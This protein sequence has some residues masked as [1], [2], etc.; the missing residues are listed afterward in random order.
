MIRT[1]ESSA[2]WKQVALSWIVVYSSKDKEKTAATIEDY[3]SE[4]RKDRDLIPDALSAAL[5]YLEEE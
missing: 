3:V 4:G 1:G 2:F 5:N